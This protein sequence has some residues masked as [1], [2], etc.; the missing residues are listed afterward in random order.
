[1][2]T[3]TAYAQ[4]QDQ[5]QPKKPAQAP[6]PN[7]SKNPSLKSVLDNQMVMH[8]ADWTL[9]TFLAFVSEKTKAHFVIQEGLEKLPVTS[10]SMQGTANEVL[11]KTL[12]SK[13]IAIARVGLD[14]IYVA[15]RPPSNG[16]M[17]K[18]PSQSIQDPS[19]DKSVTVSLKSAP[20]HVYLD[21]VAKQA[22]IKIS[23]NTAIGN[24]PF[25]AVV[26][27]MKVR[28]IFFVV[29]LTK[30]LTYHKNASGVYEFAQA[31]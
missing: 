13:G 4:P 21:A 11:H 24:K 28:D 30:T 1:M 7:Q 6:V 27:D 17:P 10:H 25:T 23:V 15:L 22:D 3:P 18:D 14:N 8:Q 16:P 19:L 31:K 12:D 2:A 26:Q 20:L 9:T 5:G 29:V